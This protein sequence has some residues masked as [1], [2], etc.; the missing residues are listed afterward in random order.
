MSRTNATALPPPSFLQVREWVL[1]RYLERP[2]LVNGYKFHLRVYILCVG[3][4]KVYCFDQILMLLAAHPYDAEDL[5]DVHKHLTNT[6][7]S[8]EDINFKVRSRACARRQC[9]E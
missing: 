6:A 4:L 2:L 8:A 5:S 3:A 9:A 1:Q 7:R